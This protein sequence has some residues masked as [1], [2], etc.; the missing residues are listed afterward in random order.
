MD[1]YEFFMILLIML[2]F[3]GITSE[4][5]IFHLRKMWYSLIEDICETYSPTGVIND[6]MAKIIAKH[7]LKGSDGKL[8]MHKTVSYIMSQLSKY[9]FTKYPSNTFLILVDYG[10][11]MLLNKTDSHLANYIKKVQHYNYIVCILC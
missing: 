8:D 10:G 6:T 9:P 1:F 11:H 4:A 5:T 7:K 2:N 3:Y